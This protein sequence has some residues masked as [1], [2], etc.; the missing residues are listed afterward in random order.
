VNLTDLRDELAVR[1]GEARA[2]P[3]AERLSALRR[4]RRNRRVTTGGAVAAAALAGVLGVVRLSGP[5]QDTAVPPASWRVDFPQRYLDHPLVTSGQ[6]HGGN[7]EVRLTPRDPDLALVAYCIG[8]VGQVS[9]AVNGQEIM[10]YGC[11]P[12]ARPASSYTPSGNLPDLQRWH[13]WNRLGVLPGRESVVTVRPA[14]GA[15][16]D[17]V[18]IAV[19]DL[20][21]EPL[22]TRALA[23]KQWI[24][25]DGRTYRLERYETRSTSDEKP[26]DLTLPPGPDGPGL[27]VAGLKDGPLWNAPT[28][29]EVDG[30]VRLD[31]AISGFCMLDEAARPHKARVSVSG[32]V[33]GTLLIAYYTQEP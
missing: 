27:I 30:T 14:S 24:T 23:L 5:W 28:K 29:V 26:L 1:A 4:R 32:H 33:N 16:A 25:N 20:R 2:T 13:E 22:E 3:T 19:Y 11:A 9:V 18:G 6:A 8:T 10:S 17:E 15:R 12:D 31:G 21:G 7:L